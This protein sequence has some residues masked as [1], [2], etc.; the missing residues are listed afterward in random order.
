MVEICEQS[1]SSTGAVYNESSHTKGHNTDSGCYEKTL[2]LLLY[3]HVAPAYSASRL[4]YNP[5]CNRPQ[6]VSSE[7][8]EDSECDC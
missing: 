7:V 8:G 2:S 5:L 1:S 6:L 3:P 4:I